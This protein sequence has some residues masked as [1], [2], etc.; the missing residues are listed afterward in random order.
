MIPYGGGRG[1]VQGELACLA[2][3]IIR[4]GKKIECHAPD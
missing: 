4:E 1:P 2:A 3:G